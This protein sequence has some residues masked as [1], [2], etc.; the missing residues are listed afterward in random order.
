MAR[1]TDERLM[2]PWKAEPG[3]G[4]FTNERRLSE[5]QIALIG[6]WAKAG[7]PCARTPCAR[8]RGSGYAND[9]GGLRSSGC[10]GNAGH[11][12]ANRCG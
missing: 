6:A 1:V 10:A 12:N 4:H 7:A 11:S 9:S 5:S 8:T 2:P 3:F